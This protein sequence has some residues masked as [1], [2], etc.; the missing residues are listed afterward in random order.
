MGVSKKGGSVYEIAAVTCS[1]IYMVG[2]ENGVTAS[3]SPD[4]VAR[5][6]SAVFTSPA[7]SHIEIV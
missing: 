1:V 3:T 5:P 6:K 4:D 7:L 2:V